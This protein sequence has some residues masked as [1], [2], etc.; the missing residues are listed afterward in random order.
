MKGGAI[1]SS[2]I[3]SDRKKRFL[4]IVD[5]DANHL[6]YVAMLFQRFEYKICTAKTAEEALDMTSVALP[7]LI[8]TD[9]N[10]MVYRVLQAVTIFVRLY[11][12]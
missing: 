6:F 5:S 12:H 7:A 1:T 4:L 3:S 2:S 8:I 11:A 10:L 9:I